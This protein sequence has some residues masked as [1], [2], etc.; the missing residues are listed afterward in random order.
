MNLK[1]SQVDIYYNNLIH[2]SEKVKGVYDF[3]R[4]E[5]NA[6]IYLKALLD[7]CNSDTVY[8]YN[9]PLMRQ[10]VQLIRTNKLKLIESQFS[11]LDFN[12]KKY[13]KKLLDDLDLS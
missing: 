1:K 8:E 3:F 11:V 9:F 10:Q 2:D 12:K 13:F 7:Q 6:I 4:K 5:A